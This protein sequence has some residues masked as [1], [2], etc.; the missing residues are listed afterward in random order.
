[1]HLAPLIKDLAVILGVAGLVSLLFHRIRQP[2]VLGYIIAGMIVGPYTPPHP[3]VS[4]ISGIKIWAEL[5]VIFLMFSLGLEFSFRK[6]ARVGLSA[7]ITACFEAFFM[8]G[9]G[10]LVGKILGWNSMDCLFLGAML[11]ISSTTIII[12]ALE[13]LN[14]KTHKFA[15]MIFAVLIVEDLLAILLLVALSTIAVTQTISS[16]ELLIA[17]GKLILVVGAWFIAGYFMIPRFVRYVGRFKNNEM[18][19][20]ISLALCLSLVVFASYFHYSVALGAFIMGSIL[21]E[22]T[23]S[24][25]IEERIESLRDLF[26]AVFFVSIGMLI[27]PRMLIEHI[28]AVILISLVT[29]FGKVLS[30]ALGSLI[31]GQTLKTSV[32][33]GFGL[34][35]IGEFSFIIAALGADLKVTSD[36]LYPIGVAVSLVTTFTTPYMIRFSSQVAEKLEKKL[37]RRAQA[38]LTQYAL[39]VQQKNAD[40]TRHKDLLPLLSR[41]IMSGLIVSVIFALSSEFLLPIISKEIE[42]RIWASTLGWL[43]TVLISSPFIWAML[44]GFRRFRLRPEASTSSQKGGTLLLI[45]ILS[46]IWIGALSIG[47]FPARYI[48][49]ANSILVIILF[50]F[51]YKRLEDG[52]HWFEKRF[53][54]TFEVNKRTEAASESLERLAPWDAHLVQIKVHANSEFI[55]KKIADSEFRTRFGLNIVAIQRGSK[56][57]VAPKPEEIILPKDELLV[58]G[59]DLQV[60]VMRPQLENPSGVME[61]IDRFGDMICGST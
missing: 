25:K 28:G 20:I 39:W 1:M 40:A 9:L 26:A 16:L 56:T 23:E 46:L 18:L 21:A 4:D 48:V 30:T 37:P 33:V 50:A 31:T 49:F 32:Q 41:W 6:L 29:I 35:Q 45:R 34:A 38:M 51:L 54:S 53:L 59:T 27:D 52:Y 11:S 12:K 60:E 44:S 5:G 22:S 2:I 14:L 42:N 13:E 47:F 17:A 57:I 24:H 19:T 10:F 8:L 61:Q 3:L 43:L 55:L 58:L 36:F 7:G 15:Q